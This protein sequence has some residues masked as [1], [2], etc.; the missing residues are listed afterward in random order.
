MPTSPERRATEEPGPV[1]QA[2]DDPGRHE[3][4]QERDDR[5]LGELIQELRVAGLGVQVLLGFMF[6][7]PFTNRFE[8]LDTGQRHL[9][10]ASLLLAAVSTALLCTPVA[11]HR[12]VF[13]RH[14]KGRV[15]R[16][17]NA[18]AIA[19]LGAVGL[20]IAG[21]VSLVV[22]FIEHGVVVPLVAGVTVATFAG[23]W[24]VLPLVGRALAVGDRPTIPTNPGRPAPP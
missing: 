5:N 12:W 8:R 10:L 15:L 4:E 7:L 6:S 13:R 23:L 24:F 20:A 2:P 21:A 14:Q 17:A 22:S 16:I 3:S 18:M 11:Y 1:T 9:Y 19:G